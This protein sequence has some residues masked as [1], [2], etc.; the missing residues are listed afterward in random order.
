MA[1]RGQ[2]VRVVGVGHVALDHVFSVATPPQPGTKTP[3]QR[4]RSLVGGMT[5]NALLAA[6]RLGAAARIVSPM[7]DDAAAALFE[8][9]FAREGIAAS[10]LLRVAGAGSSVSAVIV[11]ARGERTIVNHRGSA[12][13]LAP[14]FDAAWLR[15]ADILLT[16]PRCVHWAEAALHAARRQGLPSVLDA[17]ASPRA[18]LQRLVGLADWVVFSEPGSR[19]YADGGDTAALAGALAA[20]AQV[21]AVTQGERGLCWQRPGQAVR[22][23]PAFAVSP[24]V[25]TTAAGDVF[26]GALAVALAEG[27]ADVPALRFA[28]AAAALKCLQPDGA[29]GAPSRAAVQALLASTP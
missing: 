14:A 11:D 3:A 23:L 16:D 15:D 1:D 26:H 6:A 27:L 13:A 10:G 7:G 29:L 17:D 25:D 12:L 28:A 2:G 21:A 22:R 8:T 19:V 18:D 4:Q 9:H 24:V 5:A 20:G